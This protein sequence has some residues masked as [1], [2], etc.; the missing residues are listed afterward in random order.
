MSAWA[1]AVWVKSFIDNISNVLNSVSGKIDTAQASLNNIS[2][3]ANDTQSRVVSIGSAI[4][5]STYGLSALNT[6]LDN[7]ISELN[8]NTYGL[9]AIADLAV[10]KNVVL[11]T[12]SGTIIEPVPEGISSSDVV[13][14]ALF[15][16]EE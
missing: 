3:V 2:T 11:A 12:N 8:N 5:N 15:F 6:D 10:K 1:E 14:G 7:I 13:N 16:I 9:E 4:G